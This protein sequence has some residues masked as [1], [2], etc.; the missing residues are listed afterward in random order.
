MNE[1]NLLHQ[2]IEAVL[3]QARDGSTLQS[4]MDAF[5]LALSRHPEALR[6]FTARLRLAATDTGRTCSFSLSDGVYTPLTDSDAV[7]AA[8]LGTEDALLRVVCG[9]ESPALALLRGRL[10]IEGSKAVLLRL[11]DL[12]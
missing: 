11:G 2:E 1:K 10:R 4:L 12:L 3:A 9:R 7:D 8:L 6:G 5:C